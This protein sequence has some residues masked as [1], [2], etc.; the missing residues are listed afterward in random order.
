ML[1]YK[2]KFF[3]DLFS[4]YCLKNENVKVLMLV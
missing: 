2:D 3:E 1:K 4:N